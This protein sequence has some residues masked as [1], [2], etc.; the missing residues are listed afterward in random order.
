MKAGVCLLCVQCDSLGWLLS[1]NSWRNIGQSLDNMTVALIATGQL[2]PFSAQPP[3]NVATG[4]S[5]P[6]VSVAEARV[7]VRISVRSTSAEII[8][9]IEADK[10]AFIQVGSIAECALHT[11]G[12]TRIHISQ[13]LQ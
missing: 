6:Q 4:A 5:R 2:L 7:A 12:Y 10:A 8:S 1:F 13:H 3:S 11:L 9:A